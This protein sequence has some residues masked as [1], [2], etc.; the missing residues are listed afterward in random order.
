MTKLEKKIKILYLAPYNYTGT[1]DLFVD[2]HRRRGHQADFVTLTESPE[3]FSN[4][5]CLNLRPNAND[6]KIIALRNLISANSNAKGV[7]AVLQGKPPF[8]EPF[9]LQKMALYFYDKFYQRRIYKFINQHNLL[10]YDVYHLESGIDFFKDYRLLPMLKAKGKVL[11]ANYHGNDF[12]NRG[13][14][15]TMHATA[16]A[17]TTSEWDIFLNYPG[18]VYQYLPF[19]FNNDNKIT[20]PTDTSSLVMC[21]IV[22][23]E[24]L[25]YYK[26]TKR[27]VEAAE[28]V[29][30]KNGC[31]FKLIYGKTHKEILKELSSAHIL[32]DQI[33]GK[34]GYG[35]GMTAVEALSMGLVVAVEIQDE[36]RNLLGPHPFLEVNNDNIEKQ[37]DLLINDNI[38]LQSRS[39]NGYSWVRATH[40]V[41]SVV[42]KLYELYKTIF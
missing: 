7:R 39:E 21:H 18:C 35:Y 31:T 17:N 1:L 14:H 29:A 3:G 26:G 10:D 4:G 22:R 24:S 11:I 20:I 42:D 6:K 34:A 41:A 5:L 36:M 13:V 32:I 27:I 40:S 16:N 23:A 33:G 25:F 12:R 30:K 38:N 2:E 8:F 28:Q 9:L 37:L 15:R 19:K